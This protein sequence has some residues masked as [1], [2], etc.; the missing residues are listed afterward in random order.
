MRQ[1]DVRARDGL[2]HQ[3]QSK[4]QEGYSSVCDGQHIESDR[5]SADFILKDWFWVWYLSVF[6][7]HI[8]RST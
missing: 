6:L 1:Y 8:K 2:R 4:Y 7:M 3:I 5:G